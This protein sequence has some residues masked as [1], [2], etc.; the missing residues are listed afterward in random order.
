LQY[1]FPKHKINKIEYV[2]LEE[3][4]KKKSIPASGPITQ[5]F[6][7]EAVE[8]RSVRLDVFLDDGQIV[9]TIEMQAHE[10]AAI[11]QR[12]RFIQ[13][14]MDLNQLDRGHY[15]DQL[16][17]S[18]V[19]FICTFDLFGQELY[20]YSFEN[21]CEEVPTLRLE[22]GAHKVF[23][24]TQGTKGDISA[25]LKE[26]LRYMNDAKAYPVADTKI[27]LIREI[28]Q[29][30]KVALK[31]PKWRRNY[32]MLQLQQRDAEI[33]GEQRGELRGEQR[34]ELR[35]ALRGKK[36]DA[37]KMLA[38]G[39]PM[40]MIARITGLSLAEIQILNPENSR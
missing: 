23:F 31:S 4:G 17:P 2:Y 6:L 13:S 19:I 39:L 21:T 35:G 1:L 25:E 10:K 37:T 30:V 5:K 16:R 29:T 40:E 12:A 15:Y 26:I 27:D 33:R 20:R 28:D 8:K 18:Y 14:Q 24:N 9:Y 32:M 3:N 22:D 38:E 7:M 11:P 36:E 34:G